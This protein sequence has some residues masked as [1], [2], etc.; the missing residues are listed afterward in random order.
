[1]GPTCQRRFLHSRAPPL[2][3]PRG[4]GSPVAE[5]LPRASPF[6]SLRRGPALSEP[7]PRRGPASAHSRT[8]PDFSATTHAHALSSLLRASPVPSARP[9]PHFTQLRPDSRSTH[10]ASSRRRPA[11]AFLAIQL[12][13]D[14]TRP[15]QAPPRAET[16]A[17]V[18]VLPYSCLLLANLASPACGRA[19]TVSGHPDLVQC[20]GF[21][22]GCS[23]TS[24]GTSPSP[25]TADCPL[26]RPGFLTGVTPARPRPSL[27]RSPLSTLGF[28]A[29]SPPLSS[30][31]RSLPL[32]PTPATSEPP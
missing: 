8:S 14:R 22:P 20:P 16:P 4:P 25:T 12:A 3:L 11:P 1:V 2:S 29:S 28:V 15:P 23:P 7:P 13:G 31:W 32:C 9:P 21:G 10:A 26:W 17:P 27:C 18:L 6:P 24:T 19:R 30:P 5:S